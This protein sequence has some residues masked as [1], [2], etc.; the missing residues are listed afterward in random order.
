MRIWRCHDFP[1]E[2]VMDALRL[3]GSLLKASH[4]SETKRVG[5]WVVKRSRQRGIG[6][7]FRHTLLRG[8]SRRVWT[9]ARH[10]E[11]HG[12]SIPKAFAYVEFGRF[13]LRWGHAFICEYLD[14]HVDVEAFADSMIQRGSNESETVAYLER[15]AEAVNCLCSSGA[16]H[17]D[18]AGKN[19]LT[20]DGERFTF[21]DLDAVTLDGAYT[22]EARLRAHIQLYDSF[23]DRWSDH[24]LKPFLMHML[25]DPHGIDSWFERVKAGQKSRRARTEAIWRE[26]GKL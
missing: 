18:L 9:A 16:T 25:P 23:N 21:I 26:Q 5:T 12:V 13:G 1:V 15:L 19:I 2:S 11:N 7:L 8:R 20:Q 14:A 4:K 24:V 3:P 6:A 17:R 22:E 10:L